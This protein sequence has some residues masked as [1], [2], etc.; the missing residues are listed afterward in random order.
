MQMGEAKEA[1]QKLSVAQQWLCGLLSELMDVVVLTFTAA[2]MQL[3]MEML[4]TD[5]SSCSC[6]AEDLAEVHLKGRLYKPH[7]QIAASLLPSVVDRQISVTL[8][9]LGNG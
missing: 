5:S 2:R 6:T 3:A 8:L 7:Q 9:G 1:F 4:S